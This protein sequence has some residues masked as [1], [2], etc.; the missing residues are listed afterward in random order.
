LRRIPD[1]GMGGEAQ[2]RD[3]SM[4]DCPACTVLVQKK[5]YP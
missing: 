2:V 1:S 5:N 3:Y 4:L